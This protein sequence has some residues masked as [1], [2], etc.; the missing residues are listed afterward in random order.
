MTYFFNE[1]G[2]IR[3]SHFYSLIKDEWPAVKQKIFKE[4]VL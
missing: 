2:S 1:H 4:F 3:H